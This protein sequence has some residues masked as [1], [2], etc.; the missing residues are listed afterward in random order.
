MRKAAMAGGAIAG[1]LV[2]LGSMAGY[3]AWMRS[4]ALGEEVGE[5]AGATLAM[6]GEADA[7]A[8][9]GRIRTRDGGRYE[10]RIRW[11]GNQEA[12]WGDYFNGWREQTPWVKYAAE[13]VPK[14]REPV[15]VFGFEVWSREVKLEA[16]RYFMA[17]FGDIA[18][19]DGGSSS[20]KVTLKSGTVFELKR[21]EAS[22]FDDGLRV[23]DRGRGMVN[24]DS[25]RVESVEMLPGMGQGAAANRLHGRVQ[26]TR[27]EFA[28]FI[29][30]DRQDG[31][32]WDY[33]E[34]RA[35]KE[36]VRMRFD[37]IRTIKRRSADSLTAT[38]RDGSERVLSGT[39][40]TGQGNRGLY[41]DDE[42]FGRVLVPWEAFERVEFD[43]GGSG[44][45]YGD[46]PPGQR[47]DGSVTSVSGKRWAG[48][49]IFDLDES[50]TT[51][52]LD[53]PTDGVDYTIPFGLIESIERPGRDLGGDGRARVRLHS[54]VELRMEARGDL[55]EKNGGMLI[56]TEAGQQP[57]YVPWA[58][59]QRVEFRR[60]AAM[61]PPLGGGEKK[62]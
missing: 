54:G 21:S 61:Y 48:R 13:G 55:G 42:R 23:W 7:S 32:G 56:F 19:V 50:E 5:D 60:P 17:R 6:E 51:E 59:V 34:G 40:E 4:G 25:L 57:E 28:G 49:L 11:G 33:L 44:P 16:G 27:G 12:F 20:V 29:Q 8:I 38:L 3:R 22:D 36:R 53:A 62:R 15:E 2:I 58:E 9:Y 52:T 26:T 47:L 18:R 31:S 1:A 37:G 35:G 30:W 41:V 10:G 14:R 43:A 39:R 45:A 24:L 46:F